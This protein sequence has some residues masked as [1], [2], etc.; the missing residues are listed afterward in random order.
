MGCVLAAVSPVGAQ[1]EA[2]K[3][4]LGDPLP[5]G[6]KAR[7]GT[8]RFRYDGNYSGS[9][10]PVF[11][12]GAK[13]LLTRSGNAFQFVNVRTGNSTDS[14]FPNPG[15]AFSGLP[16]KISAD[17][18]RGLYVAFNNV[19]VLN[20]ETGKK[21]AEFK[22][23]RTNTDGG[24]TSLSRDGKFLAVGAL[25]DFGKN[26]QKLSVTV[27]QVD[28]QKTV[29][30][31]PVPQNSAAHVALAADGSTLVTWGQHQ[32]PFEAGGKPVDPEKMEG[33][34]VQLWN[35]ADGKELA[36]W[37]VDA[38]YG[39]VSAAISPDGNWIAASG[40]NGGVSIWDRKNGNKRRDL[41]GHNTIGRQLQFSPDG[42]ILAATNL[43]ATLQRWDVATGKSLDVT[44][45]PISRSYLAIRDYG[46]TES[47][48]VIASTIFNSETIVWECPSGQR[49]SPQLG[50]SSPLA[51]IAFDA[52]KPAEVVSIS[53][54]GQVMR[55]E[56][57]T[58]KLLKTDQLRH[59]D[60]PTESS[61]NTNQIEFD[62]QTRFAFPVN[63]LPSVYD[64]G[65]HFSALSLGS[66]GAYGSRT[67]INPS[68]D[69]FVTTI[70]PAFN[71]AEKTIAATVCST[72]PAERIATWK[73]SEGN[74]LASSLSSDGKILATIISAI[75]P[76]GQFKSDVVL[77]GWNL[78]DG[79]ELGKLVLPEG[80]S[81]TQLRF[82]PK[83]NSVLVVPPSMTPMEV[84]VT[85]GKKVRDFS[86]LKQPVNSIK[87]SADG[88]SVALAYPS[89]YGSGPNT[90]RVFDWETGKVT[91]TF[92]GHRRQV[93]CMDF[94]PD[95]KW[96]ATGSAD[97]TALIWSLA[98]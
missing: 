81:G 56:A 93:L 24:S 11:M 94:S 51:G 77:A 64:L 30:T 62:S 21:L 34:K 76:K 71:S 9:S 85:T 70:P 31:I 41:L 20:L 25:A 96:L 40:G 84:D 10:A 22:V 92:N 52:G 88:K 3:D 28:D 98:K 73:L 27:Y 12:P 61:F 42:K 2:G 35:V 68:G 97:T 46:F 82:V 75:P 4:A 95:G 79:K 33:Q 1:A 66:D 13:E 14:Q 32:L 49:L 58:G 29:A 89:A 67:A 8:E 59:K 47:G 50:H 80:F 83:S 37:K 6:A 90:I 23:A 63:G 15:F 39:V 86:D 60:L 26:D 65:T 53:S 54:L 72:N 48:T 16:N 7:L 19:S 74:L 78:A 36:T 5:Q 87:F 69:R 17:G 18:K 44:V 91:H 38:L 45:S 43:N 57:A 55:W